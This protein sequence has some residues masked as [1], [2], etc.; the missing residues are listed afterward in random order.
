MSLT[1]RVLIALAA[2]LAIGTAIAAM[3]LPADRIVAGAELVGELWL[4]ALRMTII[5]LVVALL[6]TGTAAAAST[7]AL[8]GVAGRAVAWFAVLLVAAAIFSALVT[9][10]L[11]AWS[12]I[13]PADAA[14]LRAGA[15]PATAIPAPVPLTAWLKT[16]IPS[17]PIAA[18]AEGAML[19]LVIFTVFFGLAVTR[20]AA[21]PQER[22]VGFF[23]GVADTML[24]VVRWVLWA[25]PLGVFALALVVGSRVGIAAAGAL[26]HYVIV[27]SAVCI[28]LTAAIYVLVLV[29]GIPAAR[30]ARAAVP[31]QAVGISTQSSLAA[32]PAMIESAQQNLGIPPRIAGLVLPLAVSVFRITSPAANFALVLYVASLYGIEP[33]LPQLLSGMALAVV[34][35]LAVV[36]LPSAIT[37]FT[38]TVPISAAMGVPI[39]VLPLL[40]AVEML[41]DIWRTVGNVTADLALTAIVAKR[42]DG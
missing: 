16:V 3:Q 36:S 25:A 30:F 10:L 17:N 21:E 20:I 14:A 42:A 23:Q 34:L 8:G 5:P 33:T 15:A 13:D 28:L 27:I 22:V 2:G 1:T 26:V 41:P 6:I 11:L 9:P 40:L 4:D 37:F 18:A 7:A 12:P 35:S 24:V 38:A 31:A 29:M 19:P 32:L 39:E